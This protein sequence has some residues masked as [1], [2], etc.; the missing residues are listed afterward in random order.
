MIALRFQYKKVLIDIDTQRDLFVANGAASVF[1]HKR[2]LYTKGR[3]P[4]S[5]LRLDKF[6]YRTFFVASN[7]PTDNWGSQQTMM[8]LAKSHS[9]AINL[10]SFEGSLRAA[11]QS[12]IVKN[13]QPV[14]ENIT[15]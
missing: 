11:G 4:V 10:R 8:D 9:S 5:L 2:L 13:P 15:N 12:K 7:Q 3:I 14:V 6:K 1:N